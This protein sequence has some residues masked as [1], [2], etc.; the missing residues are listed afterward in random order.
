VEAPIRHKKRLVLSSQSEREL[1]ENLRGVYVQ[2]LLAHF[3]PTTGVLPPTMPR[4]PK[5]TGKTRHDPLHVQLGEDETEEKYGKVS[6]PGKRRKSRV[7]EDGDE[8]EE[9][10]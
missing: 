9:A 7:N 1:A 10:R 8:A 6:R 4:A 3:R 2:A 5:P